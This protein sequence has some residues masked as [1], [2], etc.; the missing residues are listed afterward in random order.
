MFS[1]RTTWNML[2]NQLSELVAAKRL[3]GETI[4]DLTE[5]NPTRCG[6]PYLEKEILAALANESSLLYQP[7]PRGLLVARKAITDYYATNG[8]VVRAGTNDAYGEYQ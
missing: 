6:I 2:P 1:S 8:I 7:E 3:R 5:S 4:I